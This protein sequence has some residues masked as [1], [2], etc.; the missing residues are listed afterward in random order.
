MPPEFLRPQFHFT[1]PSGW[2]NDPNGLVY[3][4]GRYHL[5]YQHNPFG[6]QWGNMLKLRLVNEFVHPVVMSESV[7]DL[8]F[9]CERQ[10][11]VA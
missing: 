2:L 4:G 9:A 7:F 11:P 6:T 5:F 8:I 10:I 3:E 1:A